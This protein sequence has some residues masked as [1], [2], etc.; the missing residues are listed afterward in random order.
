MATQASNE[1]AT[2]FLSEIRERHA[3]IN[4]PCGDLAVAVGR[5]R[6]T[7]DEVPR[8]LSAVEAALSVARS[9]EGATSSNAVSPADAARDAG[10]RV[11]HA[12]ARA[13][14]GGAA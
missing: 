9:L 14:S 7:A 2:V 12:I 3:R 10:T 4:K 6:N 13:L 5:L 1:P 11:R 8:L